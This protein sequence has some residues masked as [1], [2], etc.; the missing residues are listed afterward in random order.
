MK[1]GVISDTHD[2]LP[3]ARRALSM[4]KRMNVEAILHAGDYVAMFVAKLLVPPELPERIPDQGCTCSEV[5]SQVSQIQCSAG[6]KLP[7]QDPHAYHVVGMCRRCARFLSRFHGQEVPSSPAR[8]RRR[9]DGRGRG[10][11]PCGGAQY[12]ADILCFRPP[13]PGPSSLSLSRISPMSLVRA[14]D[15]CCASLI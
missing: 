14:S 2:R 1:I 12:S 9:S 7:R 10:V 8:R 15:S 6:R 4:F 5:G 3:T 13:R 11:P